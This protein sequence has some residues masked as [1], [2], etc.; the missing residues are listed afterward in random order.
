MVTKLWTAVGKRG[1]VC[2][3]HMHCPGRAQSGRISGMSCVGAYCHYFLCYFL[4]NVSHR[5]IKGTFRLRN[6]A[7]LR[8]TLKH[9]E[10][11]NSGVLHS[12]RSPESHASC[13][14]AA[15]VPSLNPLAALPLSVLLSGKKQCTTE[16]LSSAQHGSKLIPGQSETVWEDSHQTCLSRRG[17]GHM[18]TCGHAAFL[19]GTPGE[20]SL[21][22]CSIICIL[23]PRLGRLEV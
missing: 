13:N 23:K 7:I 19:R 6:L 21:M 18:A 5:F 11:D 12:V 10:E 15:F 8:L 3:R 9:L 16:D 2:H 22:P 14:R 17:V 4:L 20:P 1:K